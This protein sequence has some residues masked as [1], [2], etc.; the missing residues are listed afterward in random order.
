MHA[1]ARVEPA[2]L[3]GRLAREPLLHFLLIGA[4]LFALYDFVGGG[5]SSDRDIRVDDNV[6]ATLYAQFNKTWHRPPTPSEMDGLVESYVRD[7]IFYREGVVLGLDR[8]DPTIKRRVSQKFVTIAE[9]SE[10]AT[11]PT[12]A[13]L[14]RWL[15]EHGERY[16]EPALISF[17]QVMFGTD[18]DRR[19]AIEEARKALAAGADPASLGD[20]RLLLPHYELYPID[21][22]QRDF[23]PQFARSLL[24][25][26]P[27]QWEG[28]V[29]SGYGIHLVRIGKVVRGRTPPLAEVRA[30]VARDYEQDRRTRS[31]EAAYA[32][33]R[34]GYRVDYSGTWRP[35]QSK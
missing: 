23:G 13:E 30:A 28:P 7:E 26:Q 35:G 21:L 12:D 4:L 31:L 15:N 14:E 27:G 5:E 33:L 24:A 32:K 3:L 8:D 11:P 34:Q 22:V 6:A 9:E 25:V 16:A 17:D 18:A 19:G 2:G 20:G 29:R 10:A 1:P